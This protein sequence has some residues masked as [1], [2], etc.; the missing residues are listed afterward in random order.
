MRTGD[1]SAAAQAL[2]QSAKLRQQ[3]D[4]AAQFVK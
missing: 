1:R 4:S 3:A 2:D